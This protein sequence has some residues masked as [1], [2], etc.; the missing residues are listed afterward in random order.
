ML[1]WPVA[2]AMVW[3]AVPFQVM[4]TQL[5]GRLRP[6]AGLPDTLPDILSDA[7]AAFRASFWEAPQTRWPWLVAVLVAVLWMA[8][9]RG[10]RGSVIGVRR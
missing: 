9:E 7:F 6:S 8:A 5:A 3:I 2:I 1:L 4:T 10:M